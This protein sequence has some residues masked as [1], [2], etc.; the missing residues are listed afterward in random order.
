MAAARYARR[1]NLDPGC[2]P[3][4]RSQFRE[5]GQWTYTRKKFRSWCGA[6]LSREPP[7]PYPL[8]FRARHRSLT[9]SKYPDTLR[10]RWRN[11][12]QYFNPSSVYLLPRVRQSHEPPNNG[13]RDR[14][15]LT[16]PTSLVKRTR[17]RPGTHPSLI[18]GDLET[19]HPM[20]SSILEKAI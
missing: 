1:N 15:L 5:S 4:L 3:G 18:C 7:E 8:R 2:W 11:D 17:C 6:S 16:G 12:F 13:S 20:S 9:S 10:C 19:H 14:G